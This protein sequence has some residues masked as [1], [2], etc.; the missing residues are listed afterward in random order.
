[1]NSRSLGHRAPLLWLMLPFIGGLAVAKLTGC[2]LVL[3]PLLLALAAAAAAVLA[4]GGKT[5]CWA[6]A[7]I[8]AMTLA[9]VGTYAF[10]RARLPGWDMRPPRE[11]Q[12]SLKVTRVFSQADPKRATG[13]ATV[14]RSGA[15]LGDLTGQKIYFSVTLRKGEP[16][17][18]RSAVMSVVGV[19][20]TLPV[21]PPADTFDGYLAGAG[22]NFRLTRGRVLAIERP[23]LRYYRFCARAGARC[24][25]ILGHGIA[26]KRPA[27]AGLLR[28]MMLGTTHELSEEQ[29]ILFMQSG[30]MH[31]FA[32]S[33]L[34][35]GVIAGALQ[36]LLVLIRLPPW[37]RF[38]I[39]AVLL[40]LFVDITGASP[41]A[42]RAFAMAVFLQA[43]FVLR[44][45]A[46]LLAALLVSAFGVLLVSPLQLFSASFLMS[47]TI[48]IALLVLGLPLSEF[49]T[50]WWTPW[51]NLPKPVWQW[52]QSALDYAW[53]S[54]AAAI[55]IGIATT[56][57][58]LITGV[59]FFQLL[60]PGSLAANLVLIPAA[61]IV[62]LAGFA[63]LLSG[64]VGCDSGA[65]LCNHAAALVLWL[66][67]TFVRISVKLP[68]AFV[69]AR[70]ETAWLGSAT[71]VL[72]LV[73]LLAGYAGRWERSH[74]GWWP[75]FAIVALV[76]IFGVNFE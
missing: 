11:A 49:W 29:H 32:I 38:G 55:A 10:H 42:V 48:V 1:M 62:T 64:L 16:P 76:L 51:R 3:P 74:G 39:G 75:P 54:S 63:S 19:V 13:V 25:E 34:N 71:L 59:Q 36:T 41:S 14:T 28:A 60:T 15:H 70:F 26:E 33:G 12:V 24:H 43:A 8:M 27:L 44:R 31:L 68:G 50:G 67:E 7:V 52:W 6:A 23:A 53:R 37:A 57:V 20:M 47:Y 58:S 2:R 65:A 73:A 9:G 46:N 5:R 56:L 30:T 69:P 21:D 40:W 61:M 35:I 4:N 17:P 72:L 45:P 22:I 66:I 18:L